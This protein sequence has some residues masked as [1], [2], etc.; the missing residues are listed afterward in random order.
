MQVPFYTTDVFTSK[1]FSGAQIAVIPDA[2]TLSEAQMQQIAGELNLWS[3]VFV[4]QAQ[5]NT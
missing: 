4:N 5:N 2:D 3:T 1:A